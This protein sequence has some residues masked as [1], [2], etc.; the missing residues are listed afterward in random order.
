MRSQYNATT[1]QIPLPSERALA[2]RN[3]LRF[4]PTA[5]TVTAVVLVAIALF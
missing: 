2:G 3:R 5:L 1:I 4:L